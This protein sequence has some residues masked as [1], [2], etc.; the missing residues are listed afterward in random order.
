MKVLRVGWEE[1]GVV[2][3]DER[4]ALTSDIQLTSFV[5]IDIFCFNQLLSFSLV[6]SR[7]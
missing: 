7:G 4:K 3:V 1:A 2:T 6:N 5:E